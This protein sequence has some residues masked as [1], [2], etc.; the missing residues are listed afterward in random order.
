MHRA[1]V[2]SGTVFDKH[3]R[4]STRLGPGRLAGLQCWR[5]H[6]SLLLVP[7]WR[8]VLLLWGSP[9]PP[10]PPSP[11][12]DQSPKHPP[13]SSQLGKCVPTRVGWSQPPNRS[14]RHAGKGWRPRAALLARGHRS[15]Q[16]HTDSW[17]T[18]RPCN[19]EP[20][21]VAL[22]EER[23]SFTSW[24]R[25]MLPASQLAMLPAVLLWRVSGSV[26]AF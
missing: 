4:G 3:L 18:P 2:I 7:S 12:R 14:L 23:K 6:L 13:A 8:V 1:F 11:R 25:L 26:Q 15:R 21:E 9:S 5:L 24:V 20:A 16:Q 10:S 19:K 17:C 22:L